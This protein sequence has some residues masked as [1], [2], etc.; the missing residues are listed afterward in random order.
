ME[1]SVREAKGR[2]G[3]LLNQ[4]TEPWLGIHVS[5][6][7][8]FP[9]VQLSPPQRERFL[10]VRMDINNRCN[11]RCKMCYFSLNEVRNK[12]KVEMSISLFR[13]IA[14]DIFPMTSQLV[15]SAGAEPLCSQHFPQMLNIAGRYEIPHTAFF[16][17]GMLLHE[18][19]RRAV[20]NA[21]VQVVT[22][23]FDGATPQTYESIRRGARF[24]RV[25]QNIQALQ[26]LKARLDSPTPAIHFGIVLMKS[27]IHELPD[28]LRLA[29]QLGVAHVTASHL[30]PY[31]ELDMT[32]ETLHHHHELANSY[33]TQARQCAQELALSFDAPPNFPEPSEQTE[34][35]SASADQTSVNAVERLECYWPYRELLIRPD[36]N[37]HPC[38]YWYEDTSMGN[39]M[40][41]SFQEIWEGSTYQQLRNE[42][43]S[44]AFRPTCETCP[45][46]V[47]GGKR[48]EISEIH[49]VGS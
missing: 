7:R 44:H 26:D 29:K 33:L 41:Q 49:I 46:M 31:S 17:N 34:K 36:G 10:T 40:T 16:T 19:Q 28:L 24:D 32:N 39:F 27:N 15:I 13:K 4:K 42:L 48:L 23:S 3:H 22:V 25:V 30:V 6:Q 8:Q 20:I 2:L 35:F 43:S 37:V 14:K 12:P 1:F 38:C 21:G 5:L 18:K 45:G 47:A 9:F 11:L